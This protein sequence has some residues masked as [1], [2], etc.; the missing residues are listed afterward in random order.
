MG[1]K[2]LIG[3]AVTLLLLCA[4]WPEPVTAQATGR[5]V[6]G[7]A[8]TAFLKAWGE[9]LHN[10]RALHMVFTQEKHLRLLRQ[11]LISQGELWLKDKTLYY[12]L[13]NTD[14]IV[15]LQLHA[16]ERTVKTYYPLLKTLEVISL[17][18]TQPL[19][20]EVPFLAQDVE[21]LEQTH[22]I[23]VFAT[24]AQYTLRLTPRRSDSPVRDIHLILKDFQPLHFS[25]TEKNGNRL[26][27]HITTF[28]PDLDLADSQLELHVP[29]DVTIIYPLQ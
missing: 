17:S 15:E 28:I 9:R 19:P 1:R 24:D 14:G 27:M 11:P 25:Q 29:T 23:E 13:K 22:N 5:P 12:V 18:T 4:L 3:F 2:N 10:M 7:E 21:A 20:L 26:E 8:K 16:D 6:E